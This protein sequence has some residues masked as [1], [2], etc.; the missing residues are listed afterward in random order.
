MSEALGGSNSHYAPFPTPTVSKSN[1][2]S[3]IKAPQSRINEVVY[4]VL[5]IFLTICVKRCD[6]QKWSNYSY[7]SICVHEVSLGREAYTNS[8][9]DIC[10]Q[11]F[12]PLSASTLWFSAVQKHIR[13]QNEWVPF[14]CLM[15][16][17]SFF[18]WEKF[19]MNLTDNL[20]LT[21]CETAMF[22]GCSL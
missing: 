10:H 13:R 18:F 4:L 6:S 5:C 19:L 22:W 9:L 15:I 21:N 8:D 12:I 20:Q 3:V 2:I 7:L 11:S 17:W 16:F 1:R 14:L